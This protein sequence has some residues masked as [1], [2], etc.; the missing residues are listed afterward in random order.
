MLNKLRKSF[1]KN[2]ML[3][4]FI[5]LCVILGGTS[6]MTY[7]VVTESSDKILTELA[8]TDGDGFPLDTTIPKNMMESSRYFVVKINNLD[9]IVSVNTI[10]ADNISDFR[11]ASLGL[12]VSLSKTM[13]KNQYFNEYRY[14]ITT[15]DQGTEDTSDDI[16][17][18]I[19]LSDMER[20]TLFKTV[21]IGSA[22]LL[23][24]IML[25]VWILLL[26]FSKRAI[27]PLANTLE[28]QKK[29]ITNASHELKTPLTVIA[30]NNELLELD[31]GESIE[32]TIIAQE[33]KAMVEMTKNMTLLAKVDESAI[34]VKKKFNLSSAAFETIMPYNSLYK[35]KNLVF[36]YHI[37]DNIIVNAD[38]RIIR[39]CFV[40]ILDNANK[41]AKSFVEFEI[42][43]D[44]T[45]I[46]I[47]ARN[48]TNG[49]SKG[50]LSKY[51]ERFYRTAEV[52]GEN[53]GGSGIGLSILK[54]TVNMYD[55]DLRMYSDDGLIFNVEIVIRK[56][57]INNK[58][59]IERYLD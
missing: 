52:R 58:S 35:R 20:Y 46:Q 42:T 4:V 18:I 45:K 31:H 5:V 50:D 14:L 36:D 44:K 41:Y 12:E 53:I 47:I 6:L 38:E 13:T 32:T 11:A 56:I 16:K 25:G 8:K 7:H 33:V 57:I 24:S 27:E 28:K 22:V 10:H 40:I 19:F 23:V 29:F 49:I 15:N 37:K 21:L 55:G 51:S 30:A 54:D 3:S 59:T 1:V 9:K 26:S 34:A 48:D 43:S 39:D 17:T 2:A